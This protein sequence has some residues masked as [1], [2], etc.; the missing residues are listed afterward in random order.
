MSFCVNEHRKSLAPNSILCVEVEPTGEDSFGRIKGASIHIDGLVREA[1]A[2]MNQTEHRFGTNN[3]DLRFDNNHNVLFCQPDW[4]NQSQ[5][6]VVPNSL[7]LLKLGAIDSDGLT[8]RRE[9]GE[10]HVD[11]VVFGLLIYPTGVLDK[12]RRVGI[13]SSHRFVESKGDP[14]K[15]L[16][17]RTFCLV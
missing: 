1:P 11:T 12:Y 6:A 13:F 9:L 2:T 8:E 5:C 15:G 3:W 14:F 16:Q 7:L 10:V 4:L 17:R